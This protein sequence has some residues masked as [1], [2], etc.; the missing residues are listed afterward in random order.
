MSIKNPLRL[1]LVASFILLVA[2]TI[3]FKILETINST[4]YIEIDH[5]KTEIIPSIRGDIYT[6]D[7]QLLSVTSAKSDIRMDIAYAY[8]TLNN[9]DLKLLAKHLSDLFQDQTPEDYLRDFE[10]N[11]SNRYF[12]LKR[13]AS[14]QQIE[15]LKKTTYYQKPLQGGIRIQEHVSREKPNG[16]SAARTIGDLYKNNTPKYGLEYSYNSDL[17]GQDGKAL[18]LKEPGAG[19]IKIK[20]SGNIESKSGKDLITTIELEFQ[21][22]LEESLLRQLEKYKAHFGTAILMEV[23]TGM[24]KAIVNLKK[25][26]DGKYAEILNFGVTTRIEPGSTMK[27]AS[28]MAYLEDYNGSLEDTIDCKNGNYRFKG[29]PIDTRDSKKLGI[30]S[31]K[32]IFTHS[33]NI[34]VGRLIKKYYDENPQKFID[35]LYNFGLGEK[36]KIDLSGVPTPKIL[37]PKY[38]SWSGI[39]LP[40]ISFGYSI[41]LTP[42]DILTF[43]NSVANNGYLKHPY[44]GHA[45]REGSEL[46]KIERNDISHI[47]C[48]KNTI[49]KVK[50]LLRE[51]VK[52]GTGRKLSELPFSVSGKTGTTVKNYINPLTTEKEY[53][54]SF[55][56]FFPSDHPK[57]TCIVLVDNPDPKIGYYASEVAVPAFKEI[58]NKIYIKEGVDWINN[59]D[60]VLNNIDQSVNQ[61]LDV[62]TTL[63]KDKSVNK[64]FYP[65]V[66]G[67][68]VRDAVYLLELAGHK[69]IIQGNLGNVKR[70]YP[71]G[72]TRIKKDLAITLFT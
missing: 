33:S 49:Q 71:K 29:A 50:I 23:K 21:D 69:V 58:A 9:T 41:N 13:N 56:G 44:L 31:L 34:G 2:I 8:N 12:L 42:L 45:F 15:Q 64:T 7:Y 68:H 66:V 19:K 22:I 57:Y 11:K 4:N 24:I 70:Q 48:S 39:S 40:W 38:D 37:S 25:T 60:Y 27:L 6:Y 52:N 72:T 35:R 62:S 14:F 59:R 32:E 18:F 20:D 51:V 1:T 63:L 3:V 65:D 16:N 28:V 46:V 53:Q 5:L 30:A 54:S 17:M 55:V 61:I 36:S 47:I 43:Y 26:Q 67:L 10:Q